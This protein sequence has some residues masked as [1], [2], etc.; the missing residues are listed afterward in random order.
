[1]KKDENLIENH[2]PFP[3]YEEVHTETLTMRTLKIMPQNLIEIVT[4][5]NL[6]SA[7]LLLTQT[8][9]WLIHFKHGLINYIDTNAK[10]RHLKNLPVTGLCG[11][12]LSV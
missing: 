9:L 10:C 1:M 5:M 7:H 4:F 6:A 8:L 3:M 11:R 2:T 12:C